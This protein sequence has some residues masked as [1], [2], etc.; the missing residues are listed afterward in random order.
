VA[1]TLNSFRGGAVGFIDW[2]G[3][4]DALAMHE[5]YSYLADKEPKEKTEEKDEHPKASTGS[6]RKPK[7]G[8]QYHTSGETT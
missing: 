5:I 6:A 2:L 7:C 4:S 8:A 3:L 1:N